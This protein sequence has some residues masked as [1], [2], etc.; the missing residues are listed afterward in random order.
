MR[1][2]NA[3]E[4]VLDSKCLDVETR[5]ASSFHLLWQLHYGVTF[6]S[7]YLAQVS[8]LL[9][10][11]PILFSTFQLNLHH[12]CW[13]VKRWWKLQVKENYCSQGRWKCDAPNY[14]LNYLFIFAL[15]VNVNN[16]M[17][18]LLT[19]NVGWK[20]KPCDWTLIENELTTVLGCNTRIW[21]CTMGMAS[22][23]LFTYLSLV[24]TSPC[25]SQYT[26]MMSNTL[27]FNFKRLTWF[28]LFT[29]TS[30]RCG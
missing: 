28:Y 22:S 11:F 7:P 19:P 20:C 14:H 10:I 9:I 29:F 18:L 1:V 26:S 6:H 25:P 4:K 24:E 13:L 23:S 27:Y 17:H 15:T 2:E 5:F 12:S 30:T 3:F 16:V 21:V 8:L